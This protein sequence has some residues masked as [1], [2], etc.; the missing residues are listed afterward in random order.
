MIMRPL[1]RAASRTAVQ[2][3]RRHGARPRRPR[4]EQARRR[5]A[6]VC[7]L[8]GRRTASAA[9]AR[10]TTGAEGDRGGCWPGAGEGTPPTRRGRGSERALFASGREEATPALCGG[11][12]GEG[13]RSAPGGRRNVGRQQGAGGTVARSVRRSATAQAKVTLWPPCREETVQNLGQWTFHAGWQGADAGGRQ[14]VI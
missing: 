5:A 4:H 12:R 6:L 3:A 13:A 11:A 10:R 8:T 14:H 9:Q 2:T 1:R 7:G